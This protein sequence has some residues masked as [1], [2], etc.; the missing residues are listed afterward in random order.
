MNGMILPSLSAAL[1]PTITVA[2]AIALPPQQ[3]SF[4]V[5]VETSTN[6]VR[7]NSPICGL[8][9][10]RSELLTSLVTCIA[11]LWLYDITSILSV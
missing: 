2:V 8:P 10:V 1:R 7:V 9:E 5:G 6:F 4:S 3:Y 11:T